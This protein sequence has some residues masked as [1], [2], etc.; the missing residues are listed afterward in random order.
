MWR[1]WLGI[2][3]VDDGCGRLFSCQR[4]GL[5]WLVPGDG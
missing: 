1:R 2:L 3:A 4:R 5:D